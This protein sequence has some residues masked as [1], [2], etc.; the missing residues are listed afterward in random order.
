MKKLY[1]RLLIG[2]FGGAVIGNLLVLLTSDANGPFCS[3]ELLKRVGSPA[4]A[5]AVQ[6]LL[7][8]LLGAVGMGGMSL[9]EKNN[10]S[11]SYATILHFAVIETVFLPVAL[12]LGWIRPSWKELFLMGG[13]ILI[14]CVLIWLSLYFYYKRETKKLNNINRSKRK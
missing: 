2:F 13:G 11:L 14:V 5:Y 6:T 10:L 1:S 12:F 7:S 9:Y 3:M 4:A 8:A